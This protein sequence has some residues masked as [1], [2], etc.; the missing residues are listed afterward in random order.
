MAGCSIKVDKVGNIVEVLDKNNNNKSEL[1]SKLNSQPFIND[2]Q[3]AANIVAIANME[4]GKTLIEKG[5]AEPDFVFKVG[6]NI[7]ENFID[8]LSNVD[9]ENIIGGFRG[10]AGND[11]FIDVLSIPSSTNENTEVGIINSSLLDGNLSEV[12][13]G[14]QLVGPGVQE[15]RQKL[16]N[17]GLNY[18]VRNGKLHKVEIVTK[19]K[20]ITPIRGVVS[21]KVE[22]EPQTVSR[23]ELQ[24]LKEGNIEGI[25][26][27]S[28][29]DEIQISSITNNP[30]SLT[31]LK[32]FAFFKGKPIFVSANSIS[33][34]AKSMLV[35]NGFTD[36]GEFLSWRKELS[37]S[38]IA[39]LNG[40]KKSINSHNISEVTSKRLPQDAERGREVSGEANRLVAERL[41]QYQS[42]DEDTDRDNQLN[43]LEDIA[44][45]TGT[46]IEPEALDK[47]EFLSEG[48]EN[49]VYHKEGS[50]VVTK[51][52]NF[53]NDDTPLLFLDR[54]AIH[55]SLFPDAK[56]TLK[57]F[58]RNEDGDIV[59]VLEQK[60]FENFGIPTWNEIKAYMESL[61][62]RE[63]N[64]VFYNDDYLIEDLTDGNAIKT[65]DG[66]IIVVDPRARLNTEDQGFGG[67]KEFGK[68]KYSKGEISN[69]K[70]MSRKSFNNLLDKLLSV[71]REVNPRI[72]V[73][74]DVNEL[75]KNLQAL[76]FFLGN[77][78]R[79][80]Y[81]DFLEKNNVPKDKIEK[82]LNFLHDLEDNK[83]NT[84]AIKAIVH[85]IG[86]G[87]FD[88]IHNMEHVE[89][90]LKLAEKNKVDPLQYKS[91][92]LII[93]E[94]T[95]SEIFGEE[96][97]DPDTVPQ[98]TNR[99]EIGEGV[100]VYD[101]EESEEAQRAVTKI[102]FNKF[103]YDKKED[104]S[105][106]PWCLSTY[107]ATGEPTSSAKSFWFNT[108]TS[109]G[110]KI[111]FKD[112]KPIAFM[113]HSENTESDIWWDLNDENSNNLPLPDGNYIMPD[114]EVVSHRDESSR[115]SEMLDELV[116]NGD[117][118][119][120][121]RERGNEILGS[122]YPELLSTLVNMYYEG[123]SLDYTDSSLEL[124]RLGSEIE[125]FREDDLR[126]KAAFD[127]ADYELNSRYPEDN[128][129]FDEDDIAKY[130]EIVNHLTNEF[131]EDDDVP[132]GM[133]Y[134][135]RTLESFRNFELHSQI[136]DEIK[137]QLLSGNISNGLKIAIEEYAALKIANEKDS[138]EFND[139]V[140]ERISYE[141]DVIQEFI[142][143]KES[144]GYDVI[145]DSLKEEIFAEV[146]FAEY[147]NARTP[148]DDVFDLSIIKDEI[149]ED[150][151]DV[152]DEGLN[153]LYDD[154]GNIK[155]AK[156]PNGTIYLNPEEVNAETP[157]H[158]FSHV[159]EELNP[160]EW[161][162]GVELLKSTKDGKEIFKKLKE[163]GNY[164]LEDEKLWSESLNHLIGKEGEKYYNK[165]R[166]S[167]AF[168][169]VLDWIKNFFNNLG[170]S[171]G[172]QNENIDR[173]L[174]L[175]DFTNK[176]IKQEL[177]ENSLDVEDEGVR[178]MKSEE[179][180]KE[181]AAIKEKAIKDG[182]FMK[183]PNGKDSNL[184]EDQ[185]L[186]VR[187]MNF[188][189]WFGEWEN[190]P[191]NAS[192]VV[193]ENGEPLVVYHGTENRVDKD[194]NISY[195]PNSDKFYTFDSSKKS[196]VR[197]RK[198]L[199]HFFTSNRDLA[200]NYA[201]WS[202]YG[203]IHEVFL[204]IR[205]IDEIDAKGG[206][207]S[208]IGKG[209]STDTFADKIID[210]NLD[211][212]IIRNVVDVN[213]M[214]TE[215]QG[216]PSDLYIVID[217]NRIKSATENIGTY[218]DGENDIRF[219]IDSEH[220]LSHKDLKELDKAYFEALDKGDEQSAQEIVREVAK[221]KGYEEGAD[222]KMAHKAPRNGY[223]TDEERRKEI[224]EEGAN[225]NIEDW[226]LGYS[227]MPGD[228]MSHPHYYGVVKVEDYESLHAVRDAFE[229][230]QN[231][232]AEEGKVT[233]MPKVTIY[234]AVPKGVK[235]TSL[236][237]GDW[238]TPSRAYAKLHGES[239]IKGGY[240]IIV[241]EV[242]ANTL[243]WNGDSINE[244]G[245]DD[246]KDYA[247]KN[248]KNN[249]KE[250]ATI[251]RDDK[252][253]I[254]PPSKRFNSRKVDVRYQ[255]IG[256]KGAMS[257]DGT[258]RSKEDNLSN[259]ITKLQ[260]EI[261]DTTNSVVVRNVN[262][263]PNHIY[264][265]N[266]EVFDLGVW[267][268]FYDIASDT[269]YINPN[270]VTSNQELQK[271]WLHEVG[272]HKGIRGLIKDKKVRNELFRQIADSVEELIKT[273]EEYKRIYD[274]VKRLYPGASRELLGE[275][276]LAKIAEKKKFG[277]KLS[278]SETSFWNSIINKISAF[279]DKLFGS[280][281]LLSKRQIEE[282]VIASIN[283]ISVDSLVAEKEAEFNESERFMMS[284]KNSYKDENIK[285]Y[286]RLK[287]LDNIDYIRT[288]EFNED[289]EQKAYRVSYAGMEELNEDEM[290][291]D[292]NFSS[293]KEALEF[294]NSPI[295]YNHVNDN[296]FNPNRT[297]VPVVTEVYLD[298]EGNEVYEENE[299]QG[300]EIPSFV[301]DK[302]KLGDI[303]F[304]SFFHTKDDFL[305]S[306][307]SDNY[308]IPSVIN[309]IEEKIKEL[310]GTI[311][312]KS[313]KA[314]SKY[315]KFTSRLG[316]NILIR[317]S[318][319]NMNDENVVKFEEEF[320]PDKV[321][322]IVI[323]NFGVDNN[324][325][326]KFRDEDYA[327][328]FLSDK[329][330]K[331]VTVTQEFFNLEDIV[332]S[333][334]VEKINNILTDN[335]TPRR[336]VLM[337]KELEAD[338]M[339]DL[340]SSGAIEVSCSL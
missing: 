142:D 274:T 52:N 88:P 122:Y 124:T 75:P 44:K 262:S 33:E 58:T 4:D 275:E 212:G 166:V 198:S 197:G 31:K 225:M 149:L 300:D 100:V 179:F 34:E 112:G 298:N 231:Q 329:F 54:L 335:I 94:F 9:G 12:R 146:L 253:E 230:M 311:L 24:E 174:K 222:Y 215:K 16:N 320:N 182:T 143:Y 252:G 291:Y 338:I 105:R 37:D 77:K 46:W 189:Q 106:S 301:K 293:L 185:W 255:I 32:L 251:T 30:R 283:H 194:G 173:N 66:K 192:K 237:N 286:E 295:E 294:V 148:L 20:K 103:G 90:A 323:N 101:V 5:K 60:Y 118:H 49:K 316:E 53:E 187:A 280:K 171:I 97:I 250:V 41:E 35:E 158:E 76:Q 315:F 188:R 278:K 40:I 65:A 238:V 257:K 216:K 78:A 87:K 330:D 226:A 325:I 140:N 318:D 136:L 227:F 296:W 159:W 232:I 132:Y 74:T 67:T 242:P 111:A 314:S 305:D 220:A 57:G 150:Y 236:R 89:E 126:D 114:G 321:I 288:N 331:P 19:D 155:G 102:L 279:L 258:Q 98:F 233:N 8:A 339:K 129:F 229:E 28:N 273:D 272:L 69:S 190:D 245:Y 70:R 264:N 84:K 317:V 203:Y 107:T 18:I 42:E 73:T 177:G 56:I 161:K 121:A 340:S 147:E 144:L 43:A 219:S 254:I 217:P 276:I 131:K 110:K 284:D 289:G 45:E 234:R 200:Y 204:N 117:L 172:I 6:N 17:I 244:W 263:I 81:E 249:K 191:E 290:D 178:F 175:K 151:K 235:E 302:Y 68:I 47:G 125:S 113:A 123:G 266:K 336:Q 115:E 214:G 332:N 99:R 170:K 210:S 14:G 334:I 281:N 3:M 160:K 181:K 169:K 1:F 36:N 307:A 297:V 38:D 309:N 79:R 247:Y 55:N 51:L 167:R 120:I 63:E 39:Y 326:S 135:V 86:R 138:E 282:I 287:E 313:L 11:F 15:V 82:Y 134:R 95:E 224:M 228:F 10:M 26:F 186:S 265:Q 256:E 157:I 7:Y 303:V 27:S 59:A 209:Y 176:V 193:D 180:E 61:G 137:K 153:Y 211:G 337:S 202:P 119:T 310:G 206:Y 91:P 85:W 130:K 184:N 270:A 248:T 240:R 96:E 109:K 108:Y 72:R 306:L 23:S 269:V 260:K 261:G 48:M 205:N 156:L 327:T 128:E 292:Y 333:N 267:S 2:K 183:A 268:A 243:Y 208:D 241:E 239:N 133:V 304:E 218:S 312:K 271:I 223:A 165:S 145:S 71:F 324:T 80:R 83:Q 277:D 116:N 163:G 25:S 299:Y 221:R 196:Y 154:L 22:Q 50:D 127:I 93:E 139:A 92:Y 207:F 29:K 64:K 62:F 308:I 259:E 195:E 104:R 246:N 141:Y 319:H 285:T 199:G 21:E 13:D 152:S 213:F 162:K 168:Q 328:E 164:D 322:S 201:E